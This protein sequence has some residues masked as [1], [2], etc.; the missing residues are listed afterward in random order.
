MIWNTV[1]RLKATQANVYANIVSVKI[2]PLDNDNPIYTSALEIILK[3]KTR[4]ICDLCQ[5]CGSCK[6]CSDVTA[7]MHGCDLFIVDLF[8]L[9]LAGIEKTRHILST[10]C[11]SVSL[12]STSHYN[13]TTAMFS[14]SASAWI[15]EETFS[16]FKYTSSSATV[17]L[18]TS[19]VRSHLILFSSVDIQSYST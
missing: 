3:N 2:L 10:S 16:L 5:P 18:I 13:F 19:S 8:I 11:Q 12:L 6:L 14:K 4:D 15:D 7:H 17:H 9:K 1:F